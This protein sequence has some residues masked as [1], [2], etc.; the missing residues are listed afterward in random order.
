MVSLIDAVSSGSLRAVAG[1][2]RLSSAHDTSAAAGHHLDE[3]EMLLAAFHLFH[4]PS[5]VRQS[6]YDAD[7]QFS[8]LIGNSKLADEL[9]FT[10]A[11]GCDPI[12]RL[13]VMS[14]CNPPQNRLGHTA[15]YTEDN[16]AAGSKAEWNIRCL[17]FQIRKID[18]RGTDHIDQFG[19]RQNIVRIL[20][21]VCEAV[22][23]LRLHLLRRTRHDGHHDRSSAIRIVRR[24][25]IILLCNRGEHSLR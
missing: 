10:H 21:S 12:Q 8:V 13:L 6:G 3:I 24:I 1:K 5:G 15:G 20:L 7:L 22:R 18:S 19:R 25:T 11:A 14:F 23:S 17:R 2:T 9:I 4:H 16:T